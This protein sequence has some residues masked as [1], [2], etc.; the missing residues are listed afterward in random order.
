MAVIH[1]SVRKKR[2][3][4][5]PLLGGWIVL[6]ASLL[7]GTMAVHFAVESAKSA[8]KHDLQGIAKAFAVTLQEMDHATIT[9]SMNN[10]D[11]HY[12]SLFDVMMS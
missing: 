7:V 4:L 10:D 6:I 12:K 5:I 9:P 1:L 11:P 8:L 3:L 2:V